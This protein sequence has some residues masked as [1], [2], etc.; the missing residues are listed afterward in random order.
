MKD[1]TPVLEKRS[2]E[3]PIRIMFIGRMSYPES[4]KKMFT[5]VFSPHTPFACI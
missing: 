5:L 4:M 1:I 2:E 3:Q